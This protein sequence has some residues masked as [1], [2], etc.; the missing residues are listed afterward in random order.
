[1]LRMA[2]DI[3]DVRNSSFQFSGTATT[4]E[5]QLLLRIELSPPAFTVSLTFI[6]APLPGSRQTC[7]TVDIPMDC[8]MLHQLCS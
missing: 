2:S 8:D 3:S 6:S 5:L 7:D 1:M 4:R